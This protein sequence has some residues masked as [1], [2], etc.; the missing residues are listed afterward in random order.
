MESWE[1]LPNI[2]D[3]PQ[4]RRP[5]DPLVCDH[6]GETSPTY[7]TC[8]E[9]VWQGAHPFTM[10]WRRRHAAKLEWLPEYM[11]ESVI[12]YACHGFP[13]GGFVRA[14][15][16]NDLR[17]AV[18]S[19][20]EDNLRAIAAW[21]KFVAIHLPSDCVGSLDAY[22]KWTEVG[23]LVGRV[24]PFSK[25]AAIRWKRRQQGYTDVPHYSHKETQRD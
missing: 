23:G 2:P 1:R 19:A 18:L 25:T 12:M 4:T 3:K 24:T 5:G 6:C 13:V 14:V 10:A 11:R 15:L 16:T 22:W 9:C 7:E 8:D 17:A 20:D 21:G